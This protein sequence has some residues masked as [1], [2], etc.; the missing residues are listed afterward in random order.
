MKP[1]PTDNATIFCAPE[2]EFRHDLIRG[3]PVPQVCADC[4]CKL[5][6]DSFTIE[7]ALGLPSRMDRPLRYVCIHCSADYDIAGSAGEVTDHRG[8]E[9]KTYRRLGRILELVGTENPQAKSPD[10]VQ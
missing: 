3:Y 7:T 6:A 1:L 5:L 10:K 4:G 8:G 2:A 9:T